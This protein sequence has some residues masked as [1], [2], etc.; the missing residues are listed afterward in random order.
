MLTR[1]VSISWPRD[2]P[3][4]ASQSARITGVSSHQARPSF[5][6]LRWSHALSPRLECRNMILAQ[7]KLHLQSSSDS[8]AL[9][10]RSMPPHPAHFPETTGP[11]RHTQ[12]I[13]IFLVETVFHCVGQA[14]LELLAS[15]DPPALA[16]QCAGNTGMS[17]CTWPVFTLDSQLSFKNRWKT[18]FY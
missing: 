8:P 10:Y 12:L 11:C 2:P 14:G 18:V 4:S 17:H 1:M 9:A 13:F 15:R 6:F 7:C 16:S 5:L 3:T